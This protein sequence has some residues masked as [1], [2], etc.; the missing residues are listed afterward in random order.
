MLT[1]FGDDGPRLTLDY[2]RI[3]KTDDVFRPAQQLIM[4]HEESWPERVIRGPL[5]DADR[6][7]GVHRR[8]GHRARFPAPRTA[9]A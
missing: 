8:P 6:T 7:R 2:S 5:T 1:P 4:D 9:P 3:R